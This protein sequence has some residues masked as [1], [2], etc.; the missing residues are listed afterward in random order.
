MTKAEIGQ[1]VKQ[2]ADLRL[3]V[4]ALEATAKSVSLPASVRQVRTTIRWSAI[5][6]AIALVVSSIIKVYGDRYVEALERRVEMLEKTHTR[7]PGP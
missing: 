6:V 2:L 5:L 1:V 3:Q 7:V 4:S